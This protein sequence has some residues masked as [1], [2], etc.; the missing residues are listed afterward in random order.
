MQSTPYHIVCIEDE[1]DIQEV[2]AFNLER[3]GYQVSLADDGK[4]GLT[5]VQQCQPDLV[6]LD[7]MLPGLNGMQVCQQLKTA[8]NT[9]HIPIIMLSARSEENDIV[10]GLTGGADD[11]ITKPFSQAELMARIKVALRRKPQPS[12]LLIKNV[13]LDPDLFA[14]K[15]NDQ[16]IKLTTTE[17]KLLQAMMQKPGRAFSREQ[18]IQAALGEQTDVV[19]R[20]VDVHIRAIRKAL[21]D[22]NNIIETVRGVGYRCCSSET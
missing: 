4:K 15:V 11:Y 1:E 14:C 2:I 17:F 8:S 9:A 22:D 19:D 16:T 6:L 18:L 13:G 7:V 20:N 21:G 3:L 10:K 5:L 12:V